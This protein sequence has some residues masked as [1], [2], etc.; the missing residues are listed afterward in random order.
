MI[1]V[2]AASSLRRLVVENAVYPRR[3]LVFARFML[4]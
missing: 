4:K 3:L 2:V 1:D